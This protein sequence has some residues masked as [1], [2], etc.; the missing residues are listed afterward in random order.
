MFDA[1]LNFLKSK[2]S[3]YNQIIWGWLPVCVCF[4]N[5]LQGGEGESPPGYGS[6]NTNQPKVVTSTTDEIREVL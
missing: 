1:L 4:L 6:R 2:T 3:I 5:G